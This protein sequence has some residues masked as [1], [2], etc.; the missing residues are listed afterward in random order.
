MNSR[1]DFHLQRLGAPTE[2][3]AALAEQLVA[4]R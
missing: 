2:R 3:R 1:I 4:C